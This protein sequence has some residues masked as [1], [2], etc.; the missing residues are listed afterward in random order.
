MLH[1]WR[2]CSRDVMRC[3]SPWQAA[4]PCLHDSI[5][6]VIGAEFWTEMAALVMVMWASRILLLMQR[7]R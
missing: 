6:P 5:A 4:D 1:S 7:I 2:G 3:Y